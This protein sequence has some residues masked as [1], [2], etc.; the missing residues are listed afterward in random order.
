MPGFCIEVI[1]ALERIDAGLHFVG[2]TQELPLLRIE[3]DLAEA[4]VDVFFGL[5][6]TP[7]RQLRFRFLEQPALYMIRHQVAVR[8]DD[9]V[10]VSSFADIRALGKDGI[11]LSTRGT[12]YLSFL[13][14]QGGLLVDGAGTGNAQNLRKLLAGRGRFFYQADSML[15]AYIRSEKLDEQIKIL[16]A[17]FKVDE[18]RVA[19]SPR[20]DPAAVVRLT[21]ALQ[22][23]EAAGELAR[24][25]GRYGL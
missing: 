7:E 13:A 20:L 17:V 1:R 9:P 18:Q 22:A 8:A 25:R 16:P 6:K 19:L 23:L 2:Q 21:A 12:A 5:L 15:R 4:Q 24:I 10:Q 3:N 11:V 14:E